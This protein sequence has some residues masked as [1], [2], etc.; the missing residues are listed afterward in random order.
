MA[1]MYTKVIKHTVCCIRKH[2]LFKSI[3]AKVKFNDKHN[4]NQFSFYENWSGL[5][6]RVL[7][8]EAFSRIF[9]HENI[10]CF[11]LN[12]F[13]HFKQ[14]AFF[15]VS[16]RQ[17]CSRSFFGLNLVPLKPSDNLIR[18]ELDQIKRLTP[19]LFP[20][21]EITLWIFTRITYGSQVV[22]QNSQLTDLRPCSWKA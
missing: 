2:G 16:L 10:T 8:V 21:T 1:K 9:Q 13:S 15:S 20:L 22:T 5:I 18:S 4:V 11:E 17:N 12:L 19:P 6:F 3:H 14:V 7:Q